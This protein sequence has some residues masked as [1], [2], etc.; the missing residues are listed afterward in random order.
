M[1]TSNT[2]VVFKADSRA[3]VSNLQPMGHMPP[4]M[5]MNAAQH[6]IVNLLKTVW[7]FF[8]ITCRNV[9]NVWPKTTLL[10]SVWQWCQKVGHSWFYTQS[11]LWFH[12]L[13]RENHLKNAEN[14]AKIPNQETNLNPKYCLRT[15]CEWNLVLCKFQSPFNESL[16]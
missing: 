7:E 15:S 14:T 6:K 13:Q 4:R 3:G 5:A 2:L 11:W 12:S 8:V 9:F 1:R 10:L 16:Y